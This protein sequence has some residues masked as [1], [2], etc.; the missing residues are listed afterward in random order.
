MAADT[1]AT[2]F[3][4]PL[5]TFTHSNQIL[6]DDQTMQCNMMY[7]LSRPGHVEAAYQARIF[8]ARMLTR[9]LFPVVN[10]LVIFSDCVGDGGIL[11]YCSQLTV[12]FIASRRV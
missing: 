8:V 1:I 2:K 12:S 6:Q 7:G 5:R 10:F 3:L 4:G 9:D 11:V